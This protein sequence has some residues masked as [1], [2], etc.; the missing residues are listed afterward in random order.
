MVYPGALKKMVDMFC[1]FPGVGPK[2]AQRLAFFLLGC[3]REEVVAIA[4]AMV[5]AKD[6]LSFCPVCGSLAEDECPYCSD[7]GR[8]HYLLCIVQEPRDVLILERSGQYKGLYHVLHGALSPLDGIGPEELK[9]EQ[10]VNRI[11][12]TGIEEVIIATNPNV[13]G[14]ATA[15]YL[16]GLLKPLSVRVSRIAFGLP[17]GGDIEYADDLTLSRAL[18]GRREM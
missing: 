7:A 10:L 17:V 14:D 15:G 2:T 18:E 9:L 12:D 4:R 1:R 11:R 6:R 8:D 16:A 13:E 5:E 3:P